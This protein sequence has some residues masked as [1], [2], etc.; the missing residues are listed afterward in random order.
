MHR[1]EVR[2]NLPHSL[3]SFVGRKREVR[4]VRALVAD[5]RLVTL[6][7]SGG[8]GKTRLALEA[9]RGLVDHFAD[10]VWLVELAPL[11]E[12]RLIQPTLAFALQLHEQPGRPLTATLSDYL[13]TK[14]ILLL[15]DNCEHLAAEVASM[16][17][18]FLQVSPGLHVFV[19]SRVQL[20]IGGER[21]WSVPQLVEA[22]ATALF[23]ERAGQARDGFNPTPQN[24]TTIAEI[25]RRLDGVPLSI[26]LAAARLRTISVDEV[27]A[28][29]SDRFTLL[30]GGSR[31]ALPRHQTL[32]ATM[33]WS[34]ELLTPEAQRL[35]RRLAVFAGGFGLEA[36][37]AICSDDALDPAQVI[38]L[39]TLLVDS[40]LVQVQETAGQRRY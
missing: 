35:W 36:A 24:S 14:Q 2:T 34:H 37:E 31:T 39:V 21:T 40:S 33:D 20:G 6:T 4:Q 25:C 15:F 23:A 7:G 16:V 29:L 8:T 38:D 1:M 5:T 27:A 13:R 28:R 12:A 18:A 10:G 17:E 3:T 30:T 22:E 32:Q 11:T 9:A 26:E 19:T